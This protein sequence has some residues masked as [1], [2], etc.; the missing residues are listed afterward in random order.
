MN[1]PTGL[2]ATPGGLGTT[3]AVNSSLAA[4]KN[5]Y[6]A[7]NQKLLELKIPF[8]KLESVCRQYKSVYAEFAVRYE[9]NLTTLAQLAK[10]KNSP[11]QRRSAQHFVSLQRRLQR[12]RVWRRGLTSEETAKNSSKC[13]AN[14]TMVFKSHTSSTLIS[15]TN[16][17]YKSPS[18]V[19]NNSKQ[20]CVI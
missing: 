16:Q 11:L 7:K 17:T 15:S 10:N 19:A 13:Q 6:S 8:L 5:T 12:G 2:A 18:S 9:I 3:V 1:V 4:M 20:T 14:E